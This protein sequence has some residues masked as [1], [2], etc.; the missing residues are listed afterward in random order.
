MTRKPFRCAKLREPQPL[1]D[2]TRHLLRSAKNAERLLR[3]I[4]ELE[5]GKT[6]EHE[7]IEP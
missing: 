5:A 1:R 3:S 7:L 2:D 4:A 6:T